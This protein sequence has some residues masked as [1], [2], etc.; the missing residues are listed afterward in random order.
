MLRVGLAEFNEALAEAEALFAQ[1]VYENPNFSPLDA[2]NHH[3][4]LHYY[5]F[6]AGFLATH[7]VALNRSE[8]T[9]AYVS[10]LDAE[11]KRLEKILQ[12]W[13]GNPETDPTVPESFKRAMREVEA[14][15]AADMEADMFMENAGSKTEV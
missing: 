10:F 11:I 2:R 15:Q 12:E 9:S 14:G 6:Q 1:N 3:F 7:F 8:E 4:V 5:V 13:H